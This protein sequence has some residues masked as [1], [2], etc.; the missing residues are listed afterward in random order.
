LIHFRN[1]DDL[2]DDDMFPSNYKKSKEYKDAD[3]G[4][5]SPSE[6]KSGKGSP[7]RKTR[8]PIKKIDLGAAAI[9]RKDVTDSKVSDITGVI[10]SS[11]S[12]E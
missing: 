3:I 1:D 5:F 6:F 2:F 8:S 11:L 7:T 12:A 9:Y 4:E 10:G